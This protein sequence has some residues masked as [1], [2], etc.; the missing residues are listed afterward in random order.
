MCEPTWQVFQTGW[1]MT[2]W[3]NLYYLFLIKCFE[4]AGFF[5]SSAHYFTI[6]PASSSSDKQQWSDT[7]KRQNLIGPPVYALSTD[8]FLMKTFTI[9]HTFH[10]C[11]ACPGTFVSCGVGS[12]QWVYLLLWL[13][14]GKQPLLLLEVL[15]K[16]YSQLFN[17]Y[18]H[19]EFYILWFHHEFITVC[20]ILSLFTLCIYKYVSASWR[21][22]CQWTLKG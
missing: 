4:V 6:V 11:A 2:F 13:L 17:S 1:K 15:W 12:W 9:K 3:M 7:V 14:G 21:L 18:S 16:P 5:S 20:F 19:I 8:C 10:L 22:S